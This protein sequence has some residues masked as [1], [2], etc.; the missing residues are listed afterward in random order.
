MW[1]RRR[2]D[3]FGLPDLIDL[4]RI[5]N[6][7]KVSAAW[8]A[9]GEGPS[10]DDLEFLDLW[11]RLPE[12]SQ[13]ALL[14]VIHEMA[15]ANAKIVKPERKGRRENRRAELPVFNLCKQKG[16]FRREPVPCYSG[17]A[18][19]PGRVLEKCSDLVWVREYIPA[20]GISSARVATDSMLDTLRP[21]DRILMQSYRNGEGISL[22]PLEDE[23][24]KTPLNH[25]RMEVPGDEIYLLALNNPDEPFL[26]RIRY[27]TRGTDPHDWRLVIEADNPDVWKSY[28][29]RRSDKVV[30]Y[31][32][33]CYMRR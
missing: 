25:L 17:V 5:G 3:S 15:I 18:A 30:L 27:D 33:V 2:R 28:P 8:L 31:A 26:K 14:G 13:Q 7:T 24:D 29:M 21:G 32:K 19:G 9:F 20:S 6:E 10:K 1:G 16:A 11:K 12:K 23:A 4:F 22:E